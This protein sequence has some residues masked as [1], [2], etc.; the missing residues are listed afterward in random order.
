MKR[1]LEEE[2]ANAEAK[3][4][5]EKD[6]EKLRFRR[7]WRTAKNLSVDEEATR[8]V[9]LAKEE[10]KAAQKA[11]MATAANTARAANAV[12]RISKAI[13]EAQNVD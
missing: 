11:V 3:K 10:E 5:Y 8:R 12:A 9:A 6:F 4:Q 7:D 2:K 13:E 1:Q